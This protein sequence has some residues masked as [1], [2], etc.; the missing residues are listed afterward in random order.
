ML[1][2]YLITLALFMH[3]IGHVLF[4]MNSW[5]LS[6]TDAGRS[7]LFSGI[8]GAGQT[9]E[10]I[11]G[12]LWLGPLIGFL[13]VTW[14]YF[15]QQGWWPQLALASAALSLVLIV[16]WWGGINTSSAFFALVFDVAVI[17]VVLW[18]L[19]AGTLAS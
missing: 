13:A 9:V 15:T 4:L 6:R 2:R 11:F 19:R 16:L 3:G 10:G 5:G 17:V 7:W 14:G 12:L 1:L 18:Q 8:L